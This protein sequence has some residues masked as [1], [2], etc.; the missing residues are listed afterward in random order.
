MSSAWDE[1]QYQ[2]YRQSCLFMRLLF[3]HLE[4]I[5]RPSGRSRYCVPDYEISANPD[6]V[7]V[8]CRQFSW[9]L[10]PYL[11]FVISIRLYN[12]PIR[13]ERQES[14]VLLLSYSFSDLI[15]RL[16]QSP[17]GGCWDQIKSSHLV[18]QGDVVQYSLIGAFST[19]KQHL[20]AE[21]LVELECGG[22]LHVTPRLRFRPLWLTD[23]LEV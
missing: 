1:R 17:I 2:A 15:W 8:S 3:N 16:P 4:Q 14:S 11:K 7:L 10:L 13:F 19:A 6:G 9:V 18:I 20:V 21:G 22:L 5:D 12:H 23:D